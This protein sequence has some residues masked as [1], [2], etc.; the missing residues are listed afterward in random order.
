[1][2]IFMH[3]STKLGIQAAVLFG[4]DRSDYVRSTTR[5]CQAAIGA[6]T[7]IKGSNPPK[8]FLTLRECEIRAFG[9]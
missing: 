2:G 9:C 6:N 7:S 3:A 1:M 4:W 5:T 8:A